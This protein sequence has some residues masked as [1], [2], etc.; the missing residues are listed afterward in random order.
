VHCNVL[1]VSSLG[2]LNDATNNACRELMQGL[3]QACEKNHMVMLCGETAELGV[4][5]GS[6]NPNALVKYNW[7]GFAL[8]AYH[9]DKMILGNT[10]KPGQIIIALPE[11]GFRSNGGS[12][13][14]I[15]FELRFG[16]DWAT[17][18]QAASCLKLAAAPSVHYNAFLTKAHGWLEADF[19]PLYNMH[20]I[21][22]VT[23]GSFKSKFADD[24][25]FPQGL[26]AELDDLCDPP[27]IMKICAVW[28]GMS[29]LDCYKTWNCGQGML[30]V[31]D[32]EDVQ[33][34][35]SFAGKH[36]IQ[37]KVAGKICQTPSGQDNQ[38]LIKSK[39]NPS[40][41]LKI[42]QGKEMVVS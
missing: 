10:L 35:C 40:C 18:E 25:L 4:C 9:H 36:G 23:G 3:M 22:H 19:Q 27:D 21:V 7:A 34:F 20:L 39:F 37:A 28:R 14:R 2:E 24:V 5:V 32:K 11:V 42:V 38:V 31:I 1:D 26:S 33:S 8:G 6:S 30:V 29:D 12:T 41:E 17:N 16:P 13:V 15:A